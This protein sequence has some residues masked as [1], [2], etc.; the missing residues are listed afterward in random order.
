MQ[1]YSYVEFTSNGWLSTRTPIC[2]IN[3]GGGVCVCYA[4]LFVHF[5]DDTT[6]WNNN[7]FIAIILIAWDFK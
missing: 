4:R 5:Y 6:N 2:V 3:G 1:I 7:I